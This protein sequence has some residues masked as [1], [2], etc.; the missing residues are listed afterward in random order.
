MFIL[1]HAT[2]SSEVSLCTSL[3]CSYND[4]LQELREE[5]KNSIE[6][7][8]TEDE[9]LE[10]FTFD[11][12]EAISF[13]TFIADADEATLRDMFQFL[14]DSDAIAIIRE[15][16]FT[17]STPVEPI[18]E[19]KV[20]SVSDASVTKTNYD[21]LLSKDPSD[22][23][24]ISPIQAKPFDWHIRNDSGDYLDF[25]VEYTYANECDE[26]DRL[27]LNLVVTFDRENNTA[28]F[29]LGENRGGGFDDYISGTFSNTQSLADNVALAVSKRQHHSIDIDKEFMDTLAINPVAYN[30]IL[31]AAKAMDAFLRTKI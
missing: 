17:T 24:D 8:S 19:E 20:T 2:Q 27:S 28:W 6:T 5:V 29:G 21:L 1:I 10:E 30:D 3:H 12:D 7:L 25:E 9:I 4:A 14:H 15:Q 11:N 23:A 22:V 18:P 31:L 16:T 26:H 13:D